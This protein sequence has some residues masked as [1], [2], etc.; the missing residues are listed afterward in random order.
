MSEES[1]LPLDLEQPPPTPKAGAAIW[2]LVA[3]D[4]DARDRL[5]RATAR[6]ATPA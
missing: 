2:G 6:T 5:G 1:A 4:M 3:E